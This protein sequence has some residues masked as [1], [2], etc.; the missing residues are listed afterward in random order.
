MSLEVIMRL[1]TLIW[2]LLGAAVVEGVKNF[3]ADVVASAV[4]G[5][6]ITD[7]GSQLCSLTPGMLDLTAEP[8]FDCSG[9]CWSLSAPPPPPPLT[10]AR[11]YPTR[12]LPC[13]GSSR[14]RII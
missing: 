10:G 14:V 2:L 5:K 6:T 8:D 13:R 1:R 11:A 7:R 3:P 12:L 4:A 9:K